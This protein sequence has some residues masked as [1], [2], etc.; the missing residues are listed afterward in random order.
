[1]TATELGKELRR[2]L[3]EQGMSPWEV[4]R[5]ANVRT[6]LVMAALDG[7]GALPVEALFRLSHALGMDVTLAPAPQRARAMGPVERVVDRALNKLAPAHDDV[8]AFIAEQ[9]A[10][11]SR[12]EEF[13]RTPGFVRLQQ[14]LRGLEGS[15]AAMWLGAWLVQPALGLASRP[16]DLVVEPGGLERVREHLRRIALNPG[17]AA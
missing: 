14:T 11:L 13:A 12:L 6:A 9:R 10:L 16:I 3:D 8:F 4:S 1:M 5:R 15:D 7:S 17:G 2:L